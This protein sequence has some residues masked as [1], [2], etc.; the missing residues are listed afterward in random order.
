MPIVHESRSSRTLFALGE[1]GAEL[2]AA[3]RAS[4][5]EKVR[6]VRGERVPFG[7]GY[8]SD[9]AAASSNARTR[10]RMDIVWNIE[11]E[12]SARRAVKV[13]RGQLQAG[14]VTQQDS[15]TRIQY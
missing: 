1:A 11:R 14:L 4:S 9:A 2:E 7:F 6:D 15:P 3:V 13:R 5:L 12:R 10:L 8:R